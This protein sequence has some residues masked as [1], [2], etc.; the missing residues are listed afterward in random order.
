[1][2][3]EMINIPAKNEKED[4]LISTK[5]VLVTVNFDDR[6]QVCFCSGTTF[7]KDYPT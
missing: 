3:V 4:V 2:N 1:M 5:L 6:P 7:T